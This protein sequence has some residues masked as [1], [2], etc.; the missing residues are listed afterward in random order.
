MNPHLKD[1]KTILGGPRCNDITD[2]WLPCPTP[3]WMFEN[4]LQ[5]RQDAFPFLSKAIDLCLD[6]RHRLDLDEYDGDIPLDRAG[7]EAFRL[8]GPRLKALYDVSV[9]HLKA[10]EDYV[11]KNFNVRPELGPLPP[12]S[13]RGPLA[14]VLGL[15]RRCGQ[16]QDFFYKHQDPPKEDSWLDVKYVRELMTPVPDHNGWKRIKKWNPWLRFH[17]DRSLKTPKLH[18]ADA[19][20]LVVFGIYAKGK[21]ETMHTRPDISSRKPIVR[22]DVLRRRLGR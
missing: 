5:F 1:Q 20:I 21:Y 9:Q 8:D 19:F 3:D 11:F 13:P 17:P 15:L 18:V 22:A 4:R 7:M 12:R 14:D 6:E 16:N 2:D 10:L